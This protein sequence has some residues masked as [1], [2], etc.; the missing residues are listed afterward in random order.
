MYDSSERK[1]IYIEWRLAIK[2][3]I[4]KRWLLYWWHIVTHSIKEP[5][6]H[7]YTAQVNSTDCKSDWM[8]LVKP[9]KND[10]SIDFSELK[11]V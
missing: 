9:D 1:S 11:A 8:N 7:V 5:K 3:I 4:M 2:Y 6:Y 10:L